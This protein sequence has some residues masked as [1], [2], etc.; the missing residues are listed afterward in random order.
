MGP[1]HNLELHFFNWFSYSLI[2]SLSGVLRISQHPNCFPRQVLACISFP[3]LHFDPSLSGTTFSPEFCFI[4]L[5]KTTLN[6]PDI[7]GR[8][9]SRLKLQYFLNYIMGISGRKNHCPGPNTRGH[10]IVHLIWHFPSFQH[11][12]RA[13]T[14]L[15]LSREIWMFPKADLVI[16]VIQ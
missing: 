4:K 8:C 15:S 1:Y 5:F 14:F 13:R 10:M 6:K 2:L 9:L 12:Y 7:I 3:M 16:T 11:R